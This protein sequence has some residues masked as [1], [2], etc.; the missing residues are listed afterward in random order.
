MALQP[1]RTAAPVARLRI[2]SSV[3]GFT[4]IEIMVVVVI[5][6]ILAALV[7]PN[8]IR[9]IDDA[10]VAKARQDIRAYETALNLFR[11][12]NFKYPTTDQGLQALV[13]QP[14]DTTIRDRADAL[15]QGSPAADRLRPLAEVAIEV[16]GYDIGIHTLAQ[17]LSGN[18]SVERVRAGCAFAIQKYAGQCV[19]EGTVINT[20]TKW[21]LR[22]RP[23]EY[24][25]QRT[26]PGA[27]S[28]LPSCFGRLKN[29][30]FPWG[31][32]DSGF[33]STHAV[34]CVVYRCSK[35]FTTSL[36]GFQRADGAG[37]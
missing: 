17:W 2:P 15:V 31:P 29:S 11:L 36:A 1:N 7:A 35:R 32:V 30:V 6:G 13:Q 27:P 8:V 10:Q 34:V 21:M 23:E 19:P 26:Q 33:P 37:E 20:A 9:R 14:G 24:E 5:L 16:T 28:T 12:D 3:R 18:Y 25:T 4:L 22:A